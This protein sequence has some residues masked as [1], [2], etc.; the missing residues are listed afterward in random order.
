MSIY[1]YYSEYY[2]ELSIESLSLTLLTVTIAVFAFFLR[3]EPYKSLRNNYLKI[4]TLFVIGYI[5][6]HFFEY[7]AFILGISEQIVDV[8]LI[9]SHYVN[10]A[11]LCSL[12]SF[13]AFIIGYIKTNKGFDFGTHLKIG[14]KKNLLEYCIFF[15][16]V[17]FYIS[18]DSSYFKGGYGEL[19][20]QSG[21]MSVTSFLSQIFVEAF[22][23]ACSIIV[24]YQKGKGCSW[25]KYVKSYSLIYYISLGV[26]MYLVLS[27]GDRGPLFHVAI[28]YIVTYFIINKRKLS[29]YKTVLCLILAV[30]FLSFLGIMR[31]MDGDLSVSKIEAANDDRN[32]RMKGENA[33]FANTSELSK[34]VRAYHVLYY[35]TNENS[36]IYGLGFVNQL[37]GI[38]Q[39]LRFVLYPILGIDIESSSTFVTTLMDSDHGMGTTCVADTY[40]NL[41]FWGCIIAFFLWG[42]FVRKMDIS[43]YDITQKTSPFVLCVILC[44]FSYVITIGRATFFAPIG[45]IAYSYLFLVLNS[46][47][48]KK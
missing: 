31:E 8:D 13:L 25:I 34:V 39:G 19:M 10:S 48:V 6:V 11:A 1:R 15:S 2:S 22:Q 36:I 21:G 32:V 45:I 7:L 44:Y 30:C 3:K 37:L 40:F 5:I 24:I 16:T 23:V 38:I 9:D 14:S 12:C 35:Y 26:Y 47:M 43:S 29:L 27:S 41:G 46:F 33:I 18:T 4:S 42:C 28:C 20:N 17:L